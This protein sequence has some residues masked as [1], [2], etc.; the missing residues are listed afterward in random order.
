MRKRIINWL[1]ITQRGYELFVNVKK[2]Y[3]LLMHHFNILIKNTDIER[4]KDVH[5]I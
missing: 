4:G 3:Q 2:Y 1:D 5:Q